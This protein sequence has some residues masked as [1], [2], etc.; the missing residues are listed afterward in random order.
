MVSYLQVTNENTL[1]LLTEV[2]HKIKNSLGGIG[3]FAALLERDLGPDDPRT[4][5]SVRIQNGVIRTNDFVVNLMEFL[6]EPELSIARINPV[7]VIQQAWNELWEESNLPEPDLPL[8]IDGGSVPPEWDVDLDTFHKLVFHAF[9][10][11][12]INGGAID[13]VRLVREKK[14]TDRFQVFFPIGP[15]LE[16]E[17]GPGHPRIR[18]C[19]PI[20][21]K[22]SLYIVIKMAKFNR[23]NVSL[24]SHVPNQYILSVQFSEGIS[25]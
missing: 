21:A 22:L 12:R 1:S 23:A 17:P 14:Q 16:L 15:Q 4:A 25:A 5:L 20:E 6:Q 8:C 11:A 2:V 3:G 18:I 13:G 7:P 9:R 10:F 19:E 24:L